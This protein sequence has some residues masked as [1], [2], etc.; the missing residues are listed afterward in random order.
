MGGTGQTG[1]IGSECHLKEIV[2]PLRAE[3]VPDKGACSLFHGQAD[4]CSTVL[5]CHQEV[6]R[7]Y[8]TL[9]IRG[10]VMKERP[11]R[12]LAYAHPLPGDKTWQAPDLRGDNIMVP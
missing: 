8:N 9:F 3:L 7:L 10:V 2:I 5:G 4:G 11:P 12:G 6:Y 1:V